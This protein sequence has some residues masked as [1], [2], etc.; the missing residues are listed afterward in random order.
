MSL[1]K[2]FFFLLLQVTNT[3]FTGHLKHMPLK[4]RSVIIFLFALMIFIAD[5]CAST[6]HHKKKRLKPGKPIPCP[7]KDC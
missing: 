6:Q 5:G 7:L 1:L 3:N 2:R 4:L